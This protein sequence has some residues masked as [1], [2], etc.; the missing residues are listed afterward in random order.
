MAALK[1]LLL[2]ASVVGCTT[3]V[4]FEDCP[5][6]GM[7]SRLDLA[8][9]AVDESPSSAPSLPPSCTTQTSNARGRYTST[10]APCTFTFHIIEEEDSNLIEYQTSSLCHDDNAFLVMEEY[11]HDW[12]DECV[13]DFSRCYSLKHHRRVLFDFLCVM[14]WNIPD[15]ATHVSVSCVEDKQMVLGAVKQSHAAARHDKVEEKLDRLELKLFNMVL[16]LGSCLAGI[17]VISILIVR[18][19]VALSSQH[20]GPGRRRPGCEC[21]VSSCHCQSS[22]RWITAQQASLV[23]DQEY[24]TEVLDHHDFEVQIPADF[25]AVPIVQARI[26]ADHE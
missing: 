2:F 24:D 15:E 20:P 17:Y 6:A 26:L 4:P 14:N 18:P 7:V 12:G 19:L 3:A 13:G 8:N 9:G 5:A 23:L 25:D 11:V 16:I 10:L 1:K 21:Q 22:G